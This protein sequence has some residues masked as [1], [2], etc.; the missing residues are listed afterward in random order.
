MVVLHNCIYSHD[1]V[2]ILKVNNHQLLNQISHHNVCAYKDI[3]LILLYNT[4]IVRSVLFSA[5]MHSAIMLIRVFL[6]IAI[7]SFHIAAVALCAIMQPATNG[8]S[9]LLCRK[10]KL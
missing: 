3:L 10:S 2:V 5:T 9:L 8:L 4:F 6:F 7:F 1:K